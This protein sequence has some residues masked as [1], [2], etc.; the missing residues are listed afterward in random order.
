MK[1]L[2]Y[3]KHLNIIKCWLVA[4]KAINR[5]VRRFTYG[6]IVVLSLANG[7]PEGTNHG[8]VWKL[9]IPGHD[10]VISKLKKESLWFHKFSDAPACHIVG[11]ICPISSIPIYPHYP[12]RISYKHRTLETSRKYMQILYHLST[13]VYKQNIYSI[14]I[15]IEYIYNI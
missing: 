10:T 8:I 1:W 6:E 11:Q 9:G 15:Y 4:M 14:Q 7:L 5:L 12:P 3:Q 13:F 2:K